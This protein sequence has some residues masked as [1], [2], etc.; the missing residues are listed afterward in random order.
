MQ[1]SAARSLS[2]YRPALAGIGTITGYFLAPARLVRSY[3]KTNL[4]PDLMAGLTVG[5]VS[6][7][8]GIAFALLAGLPAVMGVYAS[9]VAAIVGGLWGSSNQLSTGPT[10]SSSLLVFSI[11][12]PIAVPG[13]ATYIAAAG[14]LAVMS[15]LLRLVMGVARLGVLVNFVSDSVIVGF[16]AGAGVLIMVGQTRLL[17]GLSFPGSPH[18]YETVGHLITHVPE[19]HLLT[20]LLG[21]GTLVATILIK[22]F[23]QTLPAPLI[24]MGLAAL[25]V[26][27]FGLQNYGVAVLESLSRSLPP[28]A[29]LPLLDIGLIGDL[30]TG[31]LAVAVIGLVEAMAIARS[32]SA[33]TGQR[34]DSNQ[35]FVGQG[36]ANVATGFFSGYPCSGSFNRSALNLESGAR[37]PLASVFAGLVVLVVVLVFAPLAVYIP[38]SAI[39]ALLILSA[40]S[41]INRK[42]I[43]R[44][45]QGTQGDRLIMIATLASTL[46]LPLQFAVLVGVMMSLA[47]YIW[48]TSLPQVHSVVPDEDFRHMVRQNTPLAGQ[49]RP[50]CPQLGILEIQGD[51]YFGAAP[52]VESA[53]LENLKHNS[54]QR[55]LLLRMLSVTQIDISG[56]HMLESIVRTYR[57]RGG[58]VFVVRTQQ[59]VREFMQSTGFYD[60]LGGDHLFDED[61][62][63][64]TLFYKVLDPVVCIYECPVRVFKECQNLPKRLLPH[65]LVPRTMPSSKPIPVVQPQT[66]W[67]LL[68]SSQPPLIYDVRESREYHR[69][70]VPQAQSLP[71][72]TILGQPLV[73]SHEQSIVLTCRTGRRSLR[74]AQAL[75]AQGFQD[76]KILEGGLAAWEAAG[77]LEAVDFALLEDGP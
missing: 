68:R 18:L 27:V 15:G 38:L 35:E 7:P 31:A 32:I 60:L 71:L 30:S 67:S 44:I 3:S 75:A 65:D 47:Y 26:A 20:T 50:A 43:A 9:I 69:G 2:R 61:A 62:A 53:L 11:L 58:D 33:Q 49:A 45:W 24:A 13:S 10:N 16:T 22:R 57:E 59:P 41:M 19:T 56:I 17:L 4:R 12:L 40:Y 55:Y 66:L 23:K 64:S 73:V 54:E 5:V 6:L 51:L 25:A 72:V 52:Q 46:L 37:T 8:Q 39:S 36:L 1:A 21:V 76:V 77:L 42:E 74:A 63:I 14:L 34:L 28:R 70:H 29:D 48:R